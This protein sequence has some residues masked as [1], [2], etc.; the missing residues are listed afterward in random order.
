MQEQLIH[1]S[2]QTRTRLACALYS[3]PI[4]SNSVRTGEEIEDG[5]KSVSY[6]QK[7]LH[8]LL[9]VGHKKSGTS[10]IFKQV[11]S[12]IVLH[13]MLLKTSTYDR[14]KIL[15]IYDVNLNFSSCLIIVLINIS[16]HNKVH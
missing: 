16:I 14:V 2:L 11:I 4:P 1:L 9:L 8:K 7:V 12:V 13:F 10:T 6:E 15:T 3:L 5:A